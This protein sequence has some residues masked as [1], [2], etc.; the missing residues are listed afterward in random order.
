MRFLIQACQYLLISFCTVF[1]RLQLLTLFFN[2]NELGLKWCP[3][4]LEFG[5]SQAALMM[6]NGIIQHTSRLEL[7]SQWYIFRCLASK[8]TYKMN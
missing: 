6:D 7:L 4:S 3:I 8:E 1:I 2:S 5:K